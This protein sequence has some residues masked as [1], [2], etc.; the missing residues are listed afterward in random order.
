MTRRP[1]KRRPGGQP[2]NQ[3]AFKHGLYSHHLDEAGRAVYEEAL[4]LGPADLSREVA[5][6]RQRLDELI[7]HEPEQIELLTKLV[8]SLARLAAT[9]FHLSGTDTERLTR[10]MTN[11][12]H[13]IEATLGK[14]EA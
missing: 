12:L 14:G 4:R 9:H 10:A 3:N 8:N 11:V 6:C 13:D 1:P 7:K 2:G 5:I